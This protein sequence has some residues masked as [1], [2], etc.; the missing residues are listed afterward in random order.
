MATQFTVEGV[1]RVTFGCG[2]AASLGEEVKLLG[3]R[4]ALVVLDPSLAKLG[5]AAPA[6]DAL[7]KAG[8]E[9]VIYSDITREPS[10]NFV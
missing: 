1:R 3:G 5:V 4:K 7:D 10:Y 9:A 8:V 6:L 2:S